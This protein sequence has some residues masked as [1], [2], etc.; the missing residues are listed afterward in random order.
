MNPLITGLSTA[1]SSSTTIKALA[2]LSHGFCLEV[3]M[4]G[5]P[6]SATCVTSAGFST[7]TK[8]Q[9]CALQTEYASLPAS[10]HLQ[11]QVLNA[12]FY[13]AVLE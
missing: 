5:C 8:L 3:E 10:T 7:T 6:Q 9:G 13:H 1:G 11:I 12:N 4:C 2:V